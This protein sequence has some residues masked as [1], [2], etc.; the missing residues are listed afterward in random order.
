MLKSCSKNMLVEFMHILNYTDRAKAVLL[1][2]HLRCVCLLCI[3][4]IRCMRDAV[5]AVVCVCVSFAREVLS[6]SCP[7]AI[8]FSAILVLLLARSSLTSPRSFQRF[9]RTLGRNFNWIRQ[10][11][12]NF[13]IDPHCKNWPLSAKL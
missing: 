4:T 9:R 13:P 11:M 3:L 6:V 12:K 10:Q 7:S 8:E 5:L 2:S 1:T